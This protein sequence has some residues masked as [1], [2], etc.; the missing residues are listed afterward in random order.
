MG[1]SQPPCINTDVRQNAVFKEI[2]EVDEDGP[3]STSE[4]HQG[5]PTQPWHRPTTK[6]RSKSVEKR[7]KIDK[8]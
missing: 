6:T 1:L 4:H 2:H 8:I 3:E 7:R 5:Q